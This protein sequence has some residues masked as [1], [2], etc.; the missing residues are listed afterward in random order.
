MCHITENREGIQSKA[1]CWRVRMR[2][3]LTSEMGLGCSCYIARGSMLVNSVYKP[4][5]ALLHMLHKH[6]LP[7][8]LHSPN[9]LSRTLWIKTNIASHG[10]QPVSGGSPAPHHSRTTRSCFLPSSC[11]HCTNPKPP[12]KGCT[13]PE[14]LHESHSTQRR[15]IP[16]G[17]VTIS[18]NLQMQ[19]GRPEGHMLEAVGLG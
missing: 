18:R 13:L 19:A 16:A 17:R 2:D 5:P 14:S 10:I 12:P 3:T 7:T 4:M 11:S 15:Q 9:R 8:W 1:R 6:P